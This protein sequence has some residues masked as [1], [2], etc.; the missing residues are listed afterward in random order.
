[1]NQQENGLLKKFQVKG[2]EK[3]EEKA[4]Q[5]GMETPDMNSQIQIKHCSTSVYSAPK[6]LVQVSLSFLQRGSNWKNTENPEAFAGKQ[7]DPV[8]MQI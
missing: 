2:I 8:H 7:A 6:I 5:L 1:M 4:F 3:K